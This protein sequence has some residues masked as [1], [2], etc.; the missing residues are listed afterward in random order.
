MA[1][2]SLEGPAGAELLVTDRRRGTLPMDRPLVLFAG[3]VLLRVRLPDGQW[4]EHRFR[5][6]AGE[7]KR[8]H[9]KPPSPKPAPSP[10]VSSAGTPSTSAAETPSAAASAPTLATAAQETPDSD[11]SATATFLF[12]SGLGLTVASAVSLPLFGSRLH[13]ARRDLR[14]HCPAP[15]GDNCPE[16]P[17]RDRKAAQDAVDSIET[18]KAA[19]TT[20]RVGVGVGAA[21]AITGLSISWSSNEGASTTAGAQVTA[22]GARLWL[23]GRFQSAH[24]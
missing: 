19:R 7:S 8:F 22:D 6:E 3:E 2:L 24:F 4:G 1:E 10:P 11:G 13:S 14:E 17:A 20:G 21:L 15:S 5:L 18:Y 12:W 23:S 16:A 9:L